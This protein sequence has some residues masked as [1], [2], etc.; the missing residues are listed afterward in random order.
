VPG[1]S[2]FS[3]NRHGRFYESD[4]FRRLFEVVVQRCMDEGLVGGEGFAVNASLIHAD[5]NNQ[6]SLIGVD[7]QAQEHTEAAPGHPS[8]PWSL[9]RL[10]IGRLTD[11]SAPST[12]PRAF[13]RVRTAKSKPR[14]GMAL[15]SSSRERSRP[16]QT[17]RRKRHVGAMQIRAQPP[18]P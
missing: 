5:A 6:R 1:H 16:P 11:G 17:I 13:M 15:A 10:A 9:A 4:L 18:E 12:V 7:W 14:I 8:C 3:K 2:T